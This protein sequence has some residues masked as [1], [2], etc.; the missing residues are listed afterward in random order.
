MNRI[1]QRNVQIIL[2]FLI[3]LIGTVAGSVLCMQHPEWPLWNNMTFRQGL[4]ILTEYQFYCIASP[5]FW[6]AVMSALGLSATGMPLVP[7]VLFLRG[8]AFGAVL[9]RL[10]AENQFAEIGKAFLLILPYAYGTSFV[11]LFGAR[12][13]L[14][15]SIQITGLLCDKTQEE[16]T[17]VKL[18]II[19]FLVLF[20]F[21]LLLGL[22][23][24]FLLEKF[25]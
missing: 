8:M 23:Q 22:M 3:L 15:F 25:Y 24:N 11:M 14:R 20:G 21:L 5:M 12:E 7:C 10:Y 17:S 19:R 4:G 1:K 18:Y 6:L 16:E 9:E 13:A 2:L